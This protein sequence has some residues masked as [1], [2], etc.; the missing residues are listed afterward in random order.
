[1][2]LFPNEDQTTSSMN[3]K[4]T[5]EDFY[6]KNISHNQYFWQEASRDNRFES[7]DQSIWSEEIGRAHV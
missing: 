5:M 2:P 6:D 4:K 3:V 1:M 7:G